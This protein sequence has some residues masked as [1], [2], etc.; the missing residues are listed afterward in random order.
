MYQEEDFLMISG[1]QHFVFCKRQ[2]ALIHI[3]QQ[4][5]ENTL[6]VEGS[7][8]HEKADQP[9]IRE[10]RNDQLIVRAL[11]IHSRELG[12]SGIC[13]VVEFIRDD[14]GVM[15]PKYQDRFRINP[16][17][18]KRGKQKPDLSDE[19]QLT[20]QAFCLNEMLVAEIKSGELFYFETRN[21]LTVEI[22]KEKL[23]KLQEITAEM[24][25]YWRKRWTPTVKITKKC[26][27][28]SLKNVCLPVLSKKESV[29]SYM[30]RRLAE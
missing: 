11:P 8:L 12:I 9:F 19:M 15:I 5:A 24:H 29:A 3:E 30:K 18:Y 10:K 26:E 25:E 13:D 2:W 1:I 16:V 14:S 7:H 6:T 4:W 23:E 17:E 27:R 28:C 20:A 21:R 22:T